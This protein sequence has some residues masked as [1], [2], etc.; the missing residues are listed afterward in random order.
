MGPTWGIEGVVWVGD[1]R[2]GVV[3][4]VDIIK[5]SLVILFVREIQGHLMSDVCL[6]GSKEI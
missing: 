4:C 2:S 6:L 1:G 5:N 3:L